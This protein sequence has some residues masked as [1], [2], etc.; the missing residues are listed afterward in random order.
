MQR[1][2]KTPLFQIIVN[3]YLVIIFLCFGLIVSNKG[4]ANILEIRYYSFIFVTITFL[5]ALIIAYFYELLMKNKNFF[6][7]YKLSLAQKLGCLYLLINILSC[8]FSPYKSYDLITGLGRGEGLLLTSLYILAYLAIVTFGKFSQKLFSLVSLSGILIYFICTLQF[9]GFNPFNLLKG[10]AGPYNISYMGTMGNIAF[11][12]AFLTVTIPIS[13]CSFI[14]LNNNKIE[15]TLH[16]LSVLLGMLIMEVINVDSGMVALLFMFALILPVVLK[17]NQTFSRFLFILGIITAGFFVNYFINMTYFSET[18]RYGANPRFNYLSLLLLVAI[19]LLI[20]SALIVKNKAFVIKKHRKFIGRVYLSYLALGVIGLVTLYFFDFNI[21]ILSE[22]HQI[23]HGN[24]DDTFGTYR[25]FLW[26]RALLLFKDY[27]IL[28][29]GPDTFT[30]RFMPLYWQ[31][32]IKLDGYL[33][34]NDTAANI[35]LTTLIN[36]GIAGLISY[37]LLI[38][39]GVIKYLKNNSEYSFILMVA[40]LCYSVQGF[41]NLSVVIVSPYF[42]CALALWALSNSKTEVKKAEIK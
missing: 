31:E 9:W 19:S 26:K 20:V 2:S 10:I 34:I 11:L 32:L 22:I 1:S 25:I 17:N 37:I 40:V 42:W 38:S 13:V 12:S 21:R 36:I 5:I 41:F 39:E 8:I 24:I 3:I 30:L 4:Y 35:Y 16:L 14:F 18:A 33:S 29:T 7:K 27:P 23:L 28:G 6:H 15:K